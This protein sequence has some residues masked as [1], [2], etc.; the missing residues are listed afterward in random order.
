MIECARLADRPEARRRIHDLS[1]RALQRTGN[2]LNLTQA[3]LSGLDLAGFDLR[4]AIF[5]RAS[6]YGTSLVRADLTG[7]S[8]V[9]AGL[10]RT[11]FTDAVLRGAYVHALAGQASNFTR[12]DLSGLVD[13]TGALFH[14]CNLTGARLDD[15]EL[16]GT[17][18]YQCNLVE[19]HA[20]GTDLHGAV[21]N[22]CRLDQANFSR[23]RLDN[24][25]IL[26]SSVREMVLDNAR[27]QGLVLTRP[28]AADGLHLAHAHL[29][30]L[31]LDQVHARGL[32]GAHL[33]APAID[34]QGCQLPGADLSYSDVSRGRWDHVSVD[35]A[36]LTGAMLADSSWSGVTAI[37][38]NATNA[39]GEGLTATGCTF[40]QAVFTG[41][42]GRY[43]TFRNCNFRGADLRDAYLYR[44]SFIGDPP[45]SACLVKAQL[46]GANLTQAYLAADFTGASIRHA[47]ATYARVNQSTFK[48]TDLSGTSLFR[49][50]AVKTE[51]TGAR[52]AGQRGA[53]LADRCPGLLQSLRAAGDPN[54]ERVAELVEELTELLARDPGK[55]T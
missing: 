14:G 49:A 50:S 45:A 3:D 54:S 16:A 42:A 24:A 19:A 28:S 37:E 48:D 20:L 39:T 22:E 36:N 46:D 53:I 9:C 35:R 43:A 23:A 51:F 27:G 33:H 12:A 34:V 30:R 26:R 6:L 5:N 38:A 1:V 41:F 11:N 52:L 8:M 47:W 18:F 2:G 29:P 21:F 40:S 7:A 15:A 17:T 13:A 25:V 10:E 32:V 44:A 55:S 31:R 4:H